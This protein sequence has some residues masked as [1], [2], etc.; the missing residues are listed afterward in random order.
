MVSNK[1]LFHIIKEAIN[2][3]DRIVIHNYSEYCPK[4]DMEYCFETE[5]VKI[6]D[7]QYEIYFY[8]WLDVPYCHKTGQSVVCSFC[9]DYDPYRGCLI[10]A[11]RACLC[12]IADGIC[13]NIQN[14][15][16]E[17]IA[18]FGENL[19]V[20]VTCNKHGPGYCSKCNKE[21]NAGSW[22]VKDGKLEGGLY[23]RKCSV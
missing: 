18:F 2:G 7:Y 3:A 14:S 16:I 13:S 22:V 17:V 4:D 21:F 8:T 10:Q 12:E 1:H 20:V 19:K 9:P 11:Q 15:N 6:N 5:Y 23:G